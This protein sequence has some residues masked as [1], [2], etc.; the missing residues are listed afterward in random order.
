MSQSGHPREGALPELE[1][2]V[3]YRKLPEPAASWIWVCEKIQPGPDWSAKCGEKMMEGS[4]VAE[5]F[6]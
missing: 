6:V 1:N 4:T 3:F 5:H 2:E